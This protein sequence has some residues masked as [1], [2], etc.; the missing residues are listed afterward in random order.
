MFGSPMNEP[1]ERERRLLALRRARAILE[2]LALA[3]QAWDR[4]LSLALDWLL[5]LEQT[6]LDPTPGGRAMPTPLL[7]FPETLW[8]QAQSGAERV[9]LWFTWYALQMDRDDNR[10]VLMAHAHAVAD[11]IGP[12][13][14]TRL[15]ERIDEALAA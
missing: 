13:R 2:Q 3:D 14:L 10:A 4:L 9:F 12:W 5:V 7:N 11:D 6:C 15:R 1:N 8:D